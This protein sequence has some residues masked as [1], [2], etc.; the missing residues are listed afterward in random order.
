MPKR[1][2]SNM[3]MHF[4]SCCPTRRAEI[5]IWWVPCTDRWT[6]CTCR[7]KTCFYL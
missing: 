1:T 4:G 7:K 3:A 2:I 6:M 5:Q